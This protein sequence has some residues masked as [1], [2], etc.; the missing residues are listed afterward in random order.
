M[1]AANIGIH[2]NS[3]SVLSVES[4]TISGFDYGISFAS[5][6][7]GASLHVRDTAVANSSTVGIAVTGGTG[8]QATIDSV[9]LQQ[10]DTGVYVSN[11]EAT[12]RTSVTSGIGN[13]GFWA[14]TGSKV[15]IEESMATRHT[16]GFH[17][18]GGGVM[19]VTRSAATSNSGAGVSAGDVGSTIYV[20]DCTIAQN[21]TGVFPFSGGIIKTRGNNTLQ[22]NTT[23]GAFNGTF[24][25]Q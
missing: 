25:A 8:M 23:D 11:A 19:T 1:M 4:C 20:S 17:A 22:A 24:T 13:P 12:I 15:V 10:N 16:D 5:A 2:A 21:V 7:T 18:T 9:R 3:A 6:A 14:S